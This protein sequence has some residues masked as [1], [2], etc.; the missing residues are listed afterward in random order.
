MINYLDIQMKKEKKS[1]VTVGGIDITEKGRDLVWPIFM[2]FIGVVFLLNTLLIIDW[3]IW[4]Y[5]IR[6]WPVFLILGGLRL[7]F[8]H[9]KVGEIVLAIISLFVFSGIIFL[10]YVV[11][12]E[13]EKVW[14]FPVEIVE[15][16]RENFG[17]MFENKGEELSKDFTIESTDYED[18]EEVVLNIDAVASTFTLEDDDPGNYLDFES[19]YF[20]NMGVPKLEEELKDGIL[21]LSFSSEFPQG[22]ITWRNSSP[23]YTFTLGG[24]DVVNSV[25]IDLGAGKGTLDLDVAKTSEISSNIGAGKLDITLS[26]DSIPSDSLNFDIGAG[27]GTLTIPE[28]VSFSLT[29]DVGVGQI[30]F[31]SDTIVSFIGDGVYKSSNFGDVDTVLNIDVNVGA[32]AFHIVSK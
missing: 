19:T 13:D 1:K 17:N 6:F 22:T 21:N 7:V 8:G 20:D 23:T 24:K 30:D 32:G 4:L 14:F 25:Y 3:N 12:T 2:I 29:Y 5:L 10:S 18:V 9:S 11:N 26:E 28:D 27:E 16:V 31:N 15:N